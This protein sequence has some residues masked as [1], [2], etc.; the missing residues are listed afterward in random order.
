MALKFNDEMIINGT[1][2]TYPTFKFDVD[3]IT[4]TGG[5]SQ[6][7]WVGF[8][9]AELLNNATWKNE[10]VSGTLEGF[11]N[12][13]QVKI[14]ATNLNTSAISGGKFDLHCRDWSAI[15]TITIGWSGTIAKAKWGCYYYSGG[16]Y[17]ELTSSTSSNWTYSKD[18]L[19]ISAK[20]IVSND[21]DW[22][23]ISNSKNEATTYQN[24]SYTLN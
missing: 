20:N 6:P 12:G 14:S 10:I 2:W 1:E 5:G 15:K 16:K 23:S 9:S 13:G 11:L 18:H 3:S 22:I 24:F 8:F 21:N 4:P 7:I 17:K 19:I